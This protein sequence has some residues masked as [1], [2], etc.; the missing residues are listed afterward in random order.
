VQE[1]P[2][3]VPPIDV[4]WVKGTAGG[5]YYFAFGSCHRWEAHKRLGRETIKA[6]IVK[7][8]PDVIHSHLGASCPVEF[9]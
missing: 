4:L 3:D 8:T 7:C 6:K 1:S 9:K 2:E 5:N